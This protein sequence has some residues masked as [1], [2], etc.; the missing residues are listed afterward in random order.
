MLHTFG[1]QAEPER[2]KTSSLQVAGCPKSL[3]SSEAQ[4]RYC[5]WSKNAQAKLQPQ[6]HNLK[7]HVASCRFRGLGVINSTRVAEDGIVRLGINLE[8]ICLNVHRSR[9]CQYDMR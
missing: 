4:Y 7:Q 8:F 6:E 5:L 1:V 2:A 3:N 9:R